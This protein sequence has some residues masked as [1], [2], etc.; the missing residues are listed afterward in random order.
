MA[1]KG[2]RVPPVS[3]DDWQVE[4]DLRT[5]CRAREIQKDHKRM[6]KCTAMAKKKMMDLAVVADGDTE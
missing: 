5:L 6:A 2:T 4:E 3:N 1:G